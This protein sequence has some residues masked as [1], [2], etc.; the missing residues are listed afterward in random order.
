MKRKTIY[1]LCTGNSARSQMAEGFAKEYLDVDLWNVRSGGVEQHGMNPLAVKAMAEVDIDIGNQRS[2]LMDL[3]VLNHADLAV[4][5]CGD[6]RDR[7]PVP[8][9]EVRREHWGFEDP[10]RAKGSEEEKM[11]V[12]RRVRDAIGKRVKV[13]AENEGKNPNKP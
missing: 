7:C 2:E 5:L 10:A 12:F 8:P 4:T 1:F 11:K 3:E 6:A 9:E 13:F